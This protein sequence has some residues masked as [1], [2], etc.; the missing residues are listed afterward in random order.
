[1]LGCH[2][3]FIGVFQG[4]VLCHL[5]AIQT[6][7]FSIVS[8]V[9]SF[10]E[11]AGKVEIVLL[12]PFADQISRFRLQTQDRRLLWLSVLKVFYSTGYGRI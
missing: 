12:R 9:D 7:R 10:Q 4:S 2:H 5:S 8:H 3:R 6:H 11:F 1:M